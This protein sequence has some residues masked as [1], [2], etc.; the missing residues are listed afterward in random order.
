M[1]SI[2][3]FIAAV[4]ISSILLYYSS[5]VNTMQPQDHGSG[6]SDP[7]K[8]IETLLR[9]SVGRD[10][11]VELDAPRHIACDTEV[12]QCLLLEA[13]A[14][15]DGME[16][17]AFDN[18]NLAILDDLCAICNPMHDPFLVIYAS[19]DSDATCLLDIPGAPPDVQTRYAAS[20]D[21]VQDEEKNLAVQ[22]ILCPAAP[23]EVVDVMVS[24]LDLCASVLPA[25]P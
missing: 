21:L 20:M 16:I 8:V 7:Q 10:V 14:L 13:E 18:L 12:G 15:L 19:D 23:S 22:L 6:T 5:N 11:V 17:E 3:F 1:D 24:Q 9:S 25:S 4:I 2:V